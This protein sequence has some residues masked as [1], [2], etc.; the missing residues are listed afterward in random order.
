[1]KLNDYGED[2]VEEC[3]ACREIRAKVAAFNEECLGFAAPQEVSLMATGFGKGDPTPRER[4]E[5]ES[6]ERVSVHCRVCRDTG[7]VPT[8]RGQQLLNFLSEFTRLPTPG[9]KS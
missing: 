4:K 2:L 3:E 5:F 6:I 8:K 7:L 9:G 1:M